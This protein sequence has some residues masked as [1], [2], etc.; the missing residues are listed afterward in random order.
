[1]RVIK[2]KDK[3]KLDDSKAK[4]FMELYSLEYYSFKPISVGIENTSV[5]VTTDKG[6]FVL[7]I[8][9]RN[10]KSLIELRNELE[11]MFFLNKSGMPVPKIIRNKNN[12][13]LSRKKEHNNTWNYILME[14]VEG[15]HLKFGQTN[16]IPALAGYQ[17]EMHKVAQE[18]RK[19]RDERFYTLDDELKN[20]ITQFKKSNTFLAK[21]IRS[22][23]IAEITKEIIK[24]LKENFNQLNKLP[25]GLVHLDYHGTNILVNRK[26]VVGI[27]D[28]DDLSYQ[29][30]IVDLA[31][32]LL[33]WTYKNRTK[34]IQIIL[35]Q[36]LYAYQQGRKLSAEELDKIVLFMRLRNI[37]IRFN[38]VYLKNITS[39]EW[40]EI[41]DFDKDLKNIT[42][43][44]WL[45]N[46]LP[47]KKN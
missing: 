28:F 45:T 4:K 35:N 2:V 37:A 24:E 39:R 46:Q 8:Y 18:F 34:N 31:Y 14:F 42:W 15:E 40:S 44:F 38:H 47:P 1:M 30:F 7:R 5:I 13:L 32:S 12:E 36:Y 19:K 21:N 3:I 16:F 26:K 43:D 22:L 27:I 41:L 29:P 23:E 10:N 33:W 9:R 20:F 25:S 17:A 11:F 6:N